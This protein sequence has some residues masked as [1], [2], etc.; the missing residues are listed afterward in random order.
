MSLSWEEYAFGSDTLGDN[1]VDSAGRLNLKPSTVRR[2]C[3]VGEYAR[4]FE[5]YDI[6]SA[7]KQALLRDSDFQAALGED[8]RAWICLADQP[9]ASA[10]G[11]DLVRLIE[12][13]PRTVLLLA[14]YAEYLKAEQTGD[15][16]RGIGHLLKGVV[17]PPFAV[18]SKDACQD[19][20]TYSL[21]DKVFAVS[22][23][24]IHKLNVYA[25]SKRNTRRQ[26]NDDN[27]GD[28]GAFDINS[29]LKQ[30][31]GKEK[32]FQRWINRDPEV[33]AFLRVCEEVEKA[34]PLPF[35][36][37]SLDDGSDSMQLLINESVINQYV[38][39]DRG[40]LIREDPY[41]RNAQVGQNASSQEMSVKTGSPQASCPVNNMGETNEVLTSDGEPQVA[42]GPPRLKRHVHRP[43]LIAAA[44]SCVLLIGLI[45]SLKVPRA[46]AHSAPNGF[47]SPSQTANISAVSLPTV[48]EARKTAVTVVNE[49]SV[50]GQ[51]E[52]PTSS[53]KHV[54]RRP[55][56]PPQSFS[57]LSPQLTLVANDPKPLSQPP[58][59]SSPIES[60]QG[61]LPLPG[62]TPSGALNI[63][64][65]V[66]RDVQI[67]L[68]ASELEI[69]HKSHTFSLSRS[70]LSVNCK[71]NR[72]SIEGL[73]SGTLVRR[74]MKVNLDRDSVVALQNWLATTR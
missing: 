66:D 17:L 52:Q 12:S 3:K 13:E 59:I 49:K 22:A 37:V 45:V 4:S 67:H 74:K 42:F 40:E 57:E 30:L 33:E 69:T 50:P 6:G 36:T 44:L 71:Q 68:F 15:L 51:N 29:D 35:T 2:L 16:E 1:M 5:R 47:R 46:S 43:T 70:G 38:N 20:V 72:C 18:S 27:C 32:D 60:E 65:L 58:E 11:R 61:S 34:E 64:A 55:T 8:G 24:T 23:A 10:Y 56:K 73:E 28:V 62:L 39:A 25:W 31:I 21:G 41:P 7:L 9:S 26:R 14:Q 53:T 48:A 63:P 19:T 54:R